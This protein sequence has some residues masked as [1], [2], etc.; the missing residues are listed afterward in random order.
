MMLEAAKRLQELWGFRVFPVTMDGKTPAIEDFEH[1]SST[2]PAKADL[3]WWCSVLDIAQEYNIGISTAGLLVLD[4]DNK[5]GKD[6]NS[7]LLELEMQGN[8]FPATYTQF[9]PNGGMHLVYRSKEHI[10]NSAS[11]LGDGLDV[12]GGG[13]FILGA[14]SEIDGKAYVGTTDKVADAPQWLVDLCK[15]APK[16]TA[17]A[18]DFVDAEQAARRAISYLKEAPVA[19]EG[20]GGNHMAY[21][22]AAKVK[23]LG[24]DQLM[25]EAL[26]ADHW[27]ERCE[28]PWDLDELSTIVDH[29][30]RYGKNPIGMLS[31]EADFD[32]VPDEPKIVG[33][34]D[35]MNQEYGF[36]LAGGGHHI[37]WETQDDK[38]R[39][40]LQHLN[41]A[42]F[43]RAHAAKVIVGGDGKPTA[44]TKIWMNSPRRRSY[45]GFCFRPGQET[46]AGYYNLFR[47]FSVQPLESDKV[48]SAQAQSSLDAFLEH[49]LEN[50][51]DNDPKLFEWII[52]FF[53]HLF[54]KPWEKP[55]VA[56]VFKGKKGAGKTAVVERVGFLLGAH[57]LL[58]AESRYLVSNFTGHLENLLLFVLEEAFW[59]GDKNAEGTLKNLITGS[60]HVIEHKG[61]EPYTVD[62]CTRIAIIG[63]EHWTVP[64]SQDER[65]FAVFNVGDKR[66][67][68]RNFFAAMREG[69]ERGG[70]RLLLRYLLD[71]DLSKVDIN[72]AP[73]TKGLLEQK[74]SSLDPIGEWWLD[75]LQEGTVLGHPY[76]DWPE[77]ITKDD[78]RAAFRRYCDDRGIRARSP[79]SNSFTRQ[80]KMYSPGFFTDTKTN[81]RH[82]YYMPSLPDARAAW[83]QYIGHEV[84]W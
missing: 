15:K 72:Q 4:V 64:A 14:G 48:P 65:R 37:L 63:N 58:T 71:F 44:L 67:Q 51:C 17:T 68:D 39:Y 7:S 76:E 5:D 82:A 13:G 26:L 74:E 45:R 19:Q 55:L 34:V 6:G 81:G 22:V 41:E 43:H 36:I 10:G 42:S 77:R 24:V 23:D 79:T 61:K 3:F 78:A 40:E 46:P 29:V 47:G 32:T 27:N 59:S 53:A 28:P 8:E 31:P 35:K 73:K 18:P 70:Y 52:G 84:E 33:P 20:N 66:L 83:N 1:T 54:Q 57:Y 49:L 9:T 56:L 11:R 50:I 16:S 75:C 2:D 25:C 38:G 60:R 80:L 21:T 30:Y 12:R 62:N 69:M